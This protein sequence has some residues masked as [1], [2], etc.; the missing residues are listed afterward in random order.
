MLPKFEGKYLRLLKPWLILE[1]FFGIGQCLGHMLE[2]THR[3]RKLVFLYVFSKV[4]LLIYSTWIYSSF[5]FRNKDLVTRVAS[6]IN[7]VGS[8]VTALVV[9][10]SNIINYKKYLQLLNKV[11]AMEQKCRLTLKIWKMDIT[12]EILCYSMFVYSFLYWGTN[13]VFETNNCSKGN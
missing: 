4:T 8:V 1:M 13:L 9:I 10:T 2:T 3:K 7:L 5:N 12:T 6:Y 11:K